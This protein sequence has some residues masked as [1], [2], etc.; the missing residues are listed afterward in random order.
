MKKRG[1]LLVAI[2]G[3]LI[4]SGYAQNKAVYVSD[5][6]PDTMKAGQTY[7]VTVTMKNAGDTE[8]SEKEL[9]RLGSVSSG[10]LFTT[11]GRV[12]LNKSVAPGEPCTFEFKLTAIKYNGTYATNWQ[13]VQDRVEW[14]GDIVTK[15]I[16]V[17][18]GNA[19][20]KLLD[21]MDYGAKADGKTD[22]TAAFQEALTV[23]GLNGSKVTVPAGTYLIAGH[24]TIP[25]HVT[26]EGVW[27]IPP[28]WTWDA[29]K[30]SVLLA[31]ENP[32]KPD[33]TPFIMLNGTNATV[34]GITVFYP[35]QTQTDPPV[36]YPWTI[37]G[38]GDNCSVV[39]VLLVNSYMGVDFGT[40]P[41]GR[42]F[43]SNLFGQV[44]LKGVFVDQCFDVGRIENVHFWPFWTVREL[45]QS[46]TTKF[47]Y[48]NG[49]TF[50]FGKSD[51]EYVLNV[52]VY[53]YKTGFHFI[54]TKSASGITNGN[55]C[56]IGVD[57]S[58]SSI[59]V[60]N[61]APLGLLITNGEF[62]S[63]PPCTTCPQTEN[64]NQVVVKETNTGNIQFQNCAFWG[65]CDQVAK[66]AGTGVV[67]F[68][69][70][71]FV[72]YDRHNLSLPAIEVN[73]GDVIITGCNFNAVADHIYLGKEVKSAA[74]TGNRFKGT[75]NIV[76]KTKGDVQIIGNVESK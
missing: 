9:Y 41:C 38:N 30:G 12:M 73:G 27:E 42:H 70:C 50:I 55:F 13:M 31:T 61:C 21:V 45:E 11:Q 44:L 72:E 36:A 10:E 19:I 60:D 22:D 5:T 63:T 74:I 4:E 16:T 57:G 64:T 39:N 1:L 32:G 33:G 59:V 34:K 3:L 15:K 28:S 56:G 23:A 65:I 46:P 24:L 48:Y 40:R 69:N 29:S 67:T 17:V 68:N 49:E 35:N 66:I 43:I 2:V 52:F 53:G 6:I 14:F 58:Y 18:E 62:V 51:W 8:W 75:K 76:N 71:N 54:Q 25:P 26:L 47:M 7:D 37:A 20:P